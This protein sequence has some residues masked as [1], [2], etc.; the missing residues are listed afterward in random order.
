MDT[1]R[2]K[3]NAETSATK[4]RTEAI[5]TRTKAMREN[6]GAS[7]MGMVAEIKAERDRETL[8]C[9]EMEASLEEEEPTSVDMKPEVAQ[10]EKVPV[11]DATVMPV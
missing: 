1:W 11:E 8:A 7:H 4:A 5:K 6:M 10:D 2:E 9:Q 3:M